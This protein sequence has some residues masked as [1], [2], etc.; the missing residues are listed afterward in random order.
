[1]G[2]RLRIQKSFINISIR[3]TKKD[4][5]LTEF[6]CSHGGDGGGGDKHC[7]RSFKYVCFFTSCISINLP[8]YLPTWLL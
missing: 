5:Q 4:H 3:M 7:G 2:R 6:I 1:M 8:T